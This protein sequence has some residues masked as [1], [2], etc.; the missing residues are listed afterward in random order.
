MGVALVAIPRRLT[1]FPLN[2]SL[3]WRLMF[4]LPI[5]PIG[6]YSSCDSNSDRQWWMYIDNRG[7]TAPMVDDSG[8]LRFCKPSS[9]I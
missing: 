4:W 7:R 5:N 6:L 8:P 2:P 9:H 3:Q 1:K